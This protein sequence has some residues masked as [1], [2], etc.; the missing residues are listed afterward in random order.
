MECTIE[1][2]V[3]YAGTQEVL[4]QVLGRIIISTGPFLRIYEGMDKK[5]FAKVCEKNSWSLRRI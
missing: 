2:Y 1:E 3:V 4:V 5:K